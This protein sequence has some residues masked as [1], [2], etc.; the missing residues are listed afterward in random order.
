VVYTSEQIRAIAELANTFGVTVIADQLYSRL[1][2]DGTQY[3][4]LRAAGINPE[5]CVTIMGPSKAESLSGYRLGIAFGAAD[6]I[7]RMEKTQAIVS[8]RAPGYNQAVL[9]T[10]FNEPDGWMI[11]RIAQHQAIRDDL[12]RVFRQAGFAT[13]VPEAGSYL[14]PHLPALSV[15]T[16]EFVKLLRLQARVTV[17]PGAEFSPNHEQSIRLN[18]S[19][20]HRNAVA[21]VERLVELAGR[22]P[23]RKA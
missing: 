5:N 17:T 19:Q 6:V 10:Y 13:R 1:R 9:G 16:E 20:D 8:L 15:T 14:F 21:A 11:A 7:S 2:Y 22:Y 4:H 23:N 18:Y 3:T 12:V